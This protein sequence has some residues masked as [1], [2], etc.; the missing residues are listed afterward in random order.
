MDRPAEG[1]LDENMRRRVPRVR[2]V[3]KRPVDD[4]R[5]ATL[6]RL[7]YREKRDYFSSRFTNIESARPTRGVVRFSFC[8]ISFRRAKHTDTGMVAAFLFEIHLTVGAL[9]QRRSEIYRWGGCFDGVL[10][11]RYRRV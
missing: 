7:K 2:Q 1:E 3:F 11:G 10:S 4:G 6:R 5:R 8:R 9:K